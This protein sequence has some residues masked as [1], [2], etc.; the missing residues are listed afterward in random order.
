MALQLGNLAEVAQ[1]PA[2]SVKFVGRKRDGRESELAGA[3]VASCESGNRNDT[4]D[5]NF[6]L[7]TER[8]V[9]VGFR[10]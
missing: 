9:N 3:A 2:P 5:I 6:I 8:I 4:T 10:P 7:T 1:L